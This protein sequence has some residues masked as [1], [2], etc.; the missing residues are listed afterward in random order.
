MPSRSRNTPSPEPATTGPF[1]DVLA[2]RLAT[3]GP[4][5]MAAALALA[6]SHEA[7]LAL[8]ARLWRSPSPATEAVLTA[9]GRTHPSK[10][11]AKAARRA[12]FQRRSWT[13]R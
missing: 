10:V 8:L 3:A 4:D 9:L 7:Q 6:G 11:V 12:V 1:V 13:T 2:Q 5:A